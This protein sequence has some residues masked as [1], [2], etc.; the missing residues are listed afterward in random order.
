MALIW[1][2]LWPLFGCYYGLYL[3]AIVALVWMLL[4]PLFG[5]YSFDFDS[6]DIF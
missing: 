3:D 4:R 1:M 5:C 6:F 2:L